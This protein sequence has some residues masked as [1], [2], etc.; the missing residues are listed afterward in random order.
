LGMGGRFEAA[1]PPLPLARGLV[2]VLGAVGE[3][4]VLAML[5]T[6]QELSLGGTGAPQ[7]GSEEDPRD[8]LHPL[9]KHATEA[10]ACDRIPWRVR[11]NLQRDGVWLDSA[12]EI[13]RV[14]IDFNERLSQMPLIPWPRSA[15][16]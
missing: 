2:G 14:A 6:R 3:I 4:P 10:L 11:N 8:I 13:L 9:E 12:P 5:H 16:P 1:Q 15:S 7:L